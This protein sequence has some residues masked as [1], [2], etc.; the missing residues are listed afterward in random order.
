MR[1]RGG[2]AAAAD[3]ASLDPPQRK[4]TEYFSAATDR[5]GA[6]T[7]RGRRVIVSPLVRTS[8]LACATKAFG[9]LAPEQRNAVRDN[10]NTVLVEAGPGAGK[11]TLMTTVAVVLLC[12][13]LIPNDKIIVCTFTRKAARELQSR[14]AAAI[15]ALEAHLGLPCYG[16]LHAVARR[17]LKSWGVPVRV[18]TAE[19]RFDA[20]RAAL[21]T[22]RATRVPRGAADADVLVAA[23]RLRIDARGNSRPGDVALIREVDKEMASRGV[24]DVSAYISVALRELRVRGT[25]PFAVVIVDEVQDLSRTQLAFALLL[26]PRRYFVGDANQAIFSFV[27]SGRF[28]ALSA[29]EARH[30]ASTKIL[31]NN[32]RSFTGLVALADDVLRRRERDGSRQL[33]VRGTAPLGLESCPT[34]IWPCANERCEAEC[35][36]QLASQHR[37]WGQPLRTFA[38]LF[39]TNRQRGEV[40]RAMRAAGITIGG[41]SGIALST[42]HAA[43][44]LEWNVVVIIGLSETIFPC[45]VGGGLDATERAHA[46][47]EEARLLYVALTRAA[48]SLFLLRPLR[49]GNSR[50]PGDFSAPLQA[51]EGL[52]RA[53]RRSNARK[54][55]ARRRE[56]RRRAA[57]CSSREQHDA[58][59]AGTAAE[60]APRAPP[61]APRR[62]PRAEAPR[63]PPR[64]PPLQAPRAERARKDAGAPR[65]TL[66]RADGAELPGAQPPKKK[67]EP[68]ER[69]RKFLT[70]GL[71]AR[72]SWRRAAARQ[73]IA[74]LEDAARREIAALEESDALGGPCTLSE[75]RRRAARAELARE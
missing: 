4:M 62:A 70:T 49:R 18:S 23:A 51:S 54:V 5:A 41:R 52:L 6:S 2:D 7:G 36:A 34:E 63:A 73:E 25:S 14:G 21:R 48:N 40:A 50:M 3:A 28:N 35:A 67:C 43:K 38:V 44:G 32:F 46:K 29:L 55:H 9:S 30:G 24:L 19:E 71:F 60:Q 75:W 42:I 22:L 39:R 37:K 10:Q 53:L 15:G 20:V 56:Q 47:A 61:R 26:A 45:R 33:S 65:P 13:L 64:A 27:G 16:T 8:A 58:V 57:A 68:S 1:G 74:A 11:T 69:T 66:R 72:P 17:L 59:H 31:R 12:E